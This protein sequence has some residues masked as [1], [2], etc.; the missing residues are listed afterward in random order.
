M[1]TAG[2]ATLALTLAACG[3]SADGDASSTDGGDSGSSDEPVTLTISTFNEFGYDD[4]LLDE[5]MEL[6]PNVT[7]EHT[8]ADTSQAAGDALR[9][10]LG[11]GSGGSDVAAIEGDQFALFMQ[12]AD[13]FADLSDPE[14]ADRWLSWKTDQAT[15]PD[16][17]LIGYGTDIGPEG[18]CFRSDLLEEAGLPSDREGVAEWMGDT[19]EDYFKAGEEYT[20]KT[21][22]PFYDSAGAIRQGM[23]NQMEN[24]YEEDDGTIIATENPE[25]KEMYDT[26]LEESDKGLSA[27]LSQWSQD[28]NEA[29]KTGGFATTLCPGWMLGIVEGNA[30]DVTTWDITNSFPGGGGNWGGS[31]LTV[32][33][34]GEHVEEA[35]ALA[36]WLTAPEQQIKAFESKG[37]FPSQ[38]EALSDPAI[39]DAVNPYFNDAPIGQILADRADAVTVSPFKGPNYQ[40]INDFMADALGRVDVDKVDDAESSWTKFVNDV[41]GLG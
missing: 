38:V 27:G 41:N 18:I 33:A 17:K 14:L 40:A 37:T 26:L 6:N 15:T 4:G 24:A 20:E 19:W 10:A 8:K 1:A 13:K 12:Y 21:G 31:F 30:P 3:S 9:N 7:V 23:I 2:I 16:G 22:K 32:P 28:W 5:Y 25:L 29:F 11:A 34:H 36:N 35:K 39:T